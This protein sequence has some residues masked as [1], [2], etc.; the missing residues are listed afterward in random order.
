M[1]LERPFSTSRAVLDDPGQAGEKMTAQCALL[2]LKPKS[3]IHLLKLVLTQ[4]AP[5]LEK[6]GGSKGCFVFVSRAETEAL[7]ATLWNSNTKA[8]P[9]D[10]SFRILAALSPVIEGI[11]SRKIFDIPPQAV[12]KLKKLSPMPAVHG[13]VAEVRFCRVSRPTLGRIKALCISPESRRADN[14]RP[15]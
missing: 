2:R 6:Q 10:C 9:Q 12:K 5:F 1:S 8:P 7:I 14:K 3:G 13:Q 11:S 15:S 4:I